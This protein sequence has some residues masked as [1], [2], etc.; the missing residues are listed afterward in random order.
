MKINRKK[1]LKL[2]L[3]KVNEI[4]E[5][6]EDKSVFSPEE[7]VGLVVE[8]LEGNPELLNFEETNSA[9]EYAKIKNLAKKNKLKL[10]AQLTDDG[11]KEG[12]PYIMLGVLGKKGEFLDFY[13]NSGLG[14]EKFQQYIPPGFH[15]CMES[16]YEFGVGEKLSREEYIKVA[17]EVLDK[18]GYVRL[19]DFVE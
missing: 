13:Y 1:L 9:A 7:C 5:A 6:C 14:Y 18:C 16:T 8:V 10:A 11:Y 2:Y 17:F 15:E 3:K 4:A 12:M 19:E